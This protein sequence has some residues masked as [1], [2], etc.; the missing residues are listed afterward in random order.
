[1]SSPLTSQ[2]SATAASPVDNPNHFRAIGK[3]IEVCAEDGCQLIQLNKPPHGPYGFYIG[4][5]THN[6]EPGEHVRLKPERRKVLAGGN[7]SVFAF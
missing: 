3:L 4:S 5:Q 7:F 1:M 2:S 6:H